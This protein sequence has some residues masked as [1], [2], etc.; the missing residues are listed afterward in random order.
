MPGQ[1]EVVQVET[2]KRVLKAPGTKRLKQQKHDKLL[3]SFAFN[4]NLR[5]C[6]AGI[7]LAQSAEGALKALEDIGGDTGTMVRRCRL[8]VSKSVL[9]APG[10]K[11]LKLTYDKLLSIL[12]QFCFHF[13]RAPLHRGSTRWTSAPRSAAPP[14]T[15]AAWRRRLCRA[16]CTC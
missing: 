2:W 8:T 13:Q 4:F 7:A 3:S 10:T 5:R 15:A 12:P 11:R 6:S 9:K 16:S 14:P 1:G